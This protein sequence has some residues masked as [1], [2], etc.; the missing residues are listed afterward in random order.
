M[1]VE[2]KQTPDGLQLGE[3]IAVNGVCLTVRHQT[4]QGFQVD[5]SEETLKRSTLG[6]IEVGSEVN[7]ERP[8]TPGSRL[9]GHFVQ[10]HVDGI[11]QLLSKETKDGFG[12]WAFSLPSDLRSYVVE[13]GSIAV[14]GVSLTV[15]KQ[16]HTGFEVALIPHTLE[17]TNFRTL[18][19][20]QNVNLE[21]DILAKYV[22]SFLK[23]RS[24]SGKSRL[25]EAYLKEQG[26]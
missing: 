5:I 15:A 14:N 22:E 2:A 3:S 11:G 24:D 9:G 10:G 20:G 25:T 7:L 16:T 21:V 17:N 23:N 18:S 19:T 13:K 8:L 1:T 26:Y 4:Q 12:L 6:E